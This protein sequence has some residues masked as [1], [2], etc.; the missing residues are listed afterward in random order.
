MVIKV[1]YSSNKILSSTNFGDHAISIFLTHS[2]M[3]SNPFS[4]SNL[5]DGKDFSSTFHF[6]N[7]LEQL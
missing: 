2:G 5:F 3:K 1:H 6:C 4:Q 7:I